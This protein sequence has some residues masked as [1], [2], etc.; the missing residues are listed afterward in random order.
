MSYKKN[1][2]ISFSTLT[3][4]VLLLLIVA[5]N[6]PVIGQDEAIRAVED[7]IKAIPENSHLA[8]FDTIDNKTILGKAAGNPSRL[9]RITHNQLEKESTTLFPV[10]EY[11]PDF[12]PNYAQT[13]GNTNICQKVKA[14]REK[15]SNAEEWRK[16]LKGISVEITSPPI[17]G[18]TAKVKFT[19]LDLLVDLVRKILPIGA[20]PGE[21]KIF[22]RGFADRCQNSINCEI[23]SLLD[24]YRYDS[25]N[26]HPFSDKNKRNPE[27]SGYKEQTEL[28]LSSNSNGKFTNEHLPNLRANFFIKEF[29]KESVT[30]C[31]I[32]GFSQEV[33]I[34][35]G[36][37]DP[38][39]S[40]NPLGRK[41]EVY[42]A[43]YPKKS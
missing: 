9:Y 25:V 15:A 22:V 3:A 36:R 8:K 43:V 23:G 33:G 20:I 13:I 18:T 32:P 6:P 10:N 40:N 41:V 27:A 1:K 11:A 4:I 28:V 12:G 16:Y 30:N 39:E 42:V 31:K 37:V 38:R 7:V 29:L 14:L 19:K 21:I 34:L 17:L 2:L 26:V 24:G 5:C 35:Q